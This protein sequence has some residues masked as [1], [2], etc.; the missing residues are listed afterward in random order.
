MV[1]VQG[2]AYYILRACTKGDRTPSASATRHAPNDQSTALAIKKHIADRGGY[3]IWLF[4]VVR[5]EGVLALLALY[6]ASVAGNTGDTAHN[7]GERVRVERSLRRLDIILCGVY[8]RS[9]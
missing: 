6:A 9:R 2:A 8:V 5:L 3:T 4:A 7:L 1:A